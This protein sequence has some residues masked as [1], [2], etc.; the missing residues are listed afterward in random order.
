MGQAGGLVLPAAF[1]K[2]SATVILMHGLGDS[3]EGLE[4]LAQ[5][6]RQQLPHVKFVLPTAPTRAITRF[7]GQSTTAWFNINS[8][9][10]RY[11]DPCEGLEDSAD[12]VQEDFFSESHFAAN[13]R[14]AAAQNL[15]DT[16]VI[17]DANTALED[18]VADSTGDNLRARA[19]AA[20]S[21]MADSLQVELIAQGRE[22]HAAWL[23][24]SRFEGSGRWISPPIGLYTPPEITI[25]GHDY[26][27]ALRARLLLHPLEE[28]LISCPH[29]RR[30][31]R[32]I[33]SMIVPEAGEPGEEDPFHSEDPHSAPCHLA[34]VLEPFHYLDCSFNKGLNKARHDCVVQ[35]LQKFLR[36]EFPLLACKP[37][38]KV[39]PRDLTAEGQARAAEAEAGGGRNGR[40]KG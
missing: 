28:T 27:H 20:Y 26:L 2:H 35:I 40:N 39:L 11:Q 13:T 24:S 6:W 34:K 31:C 22:A 3:A 29:S 25:V 21:A 17:G 14:I 16:V 1:A 7:M 36:K 15:F 23:L 30:Q 32:S 5:A 38:D 33:H 18:D 37:E 4:D 9:S 12:F 10:D 8:N 19:E